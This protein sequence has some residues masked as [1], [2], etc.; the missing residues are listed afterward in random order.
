MAWDQSV[1]FTEEGTLLTYV[2][3]PGTEGTPA[4]ASYPR[5]PAT[6]K[7]NF[8]FK[9]ALKLEDIVRGRSAARFL[10]SDKDGHKYEMFMTDMAGLV[11]SGAVIE[12]GRCEA[13]WTFTKKGQ[14]YGIKVAK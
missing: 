7:E 6:W 9:A 1:P 2:Y 10:W 12:S 5:K 4:G 14:N 3:A 13:T 11:K 8:T